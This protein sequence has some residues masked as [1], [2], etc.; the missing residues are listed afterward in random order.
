VS[1]EQALAAADAIAAALARPPTGPNR[2]GHP[3]SLSRGAAGV[4]LLH[5]ER[6]ASGLDGWDTAH[7][8][9]TAATHGT[10]SGNS[11]AALFFGT[12]ALAFSV[13][14]A[15][16]RPGKYQ[17]ALAAL[18]ANVAA[19]TRHRLDQA[20]ARI[21]RAAR[22]ALAEF[23]LING[24][25]GLGACLLRRDPD[26]DLVRQVLAY[27]VRLTEPLPGDDLPGWWTSQPPT[28]RRPAGPGGGHGNF[29]I[30]HGIAG[31][32]ALLALA[33]RSG[34][35]TDGQIQAIATICTWFDTWQ[36]EQQGAPW[37]PETITLAETRTGHTAQTRPLRPSWC[38]G[39]PGLARAQQLAALATGDTKRLTM[40]EA[41][42]NACLTDPA[43]LARITDHSLCHG[44]AG[45]F[46]TTVRAAA[47]TPS[48]ARHLPGLSR[49]LLTPG[50][51]AAPQTGVLEGDA[52]LAL[53]LSSAGTRQLPAVGWD[54]FLLLT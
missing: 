16:D 35:R 18:D 51:A 53:A 23:D 47:D 9:L 34:I 31:P 4:A 44:W 37:W 12:P 7:D 43:Q 41:A 36:Q 6:A 54:A 52:G 46:Q 33:A 42:L 28:G 15:A 21:D 1:A 20:H 38:Y 29:G 27:L 48:L 45:L 8:W 11:N 26:G 19:I 14:A 39:T 32:L 10:L 5:I 50:T 49:Q 3:Q 13:H 30:A 2:G 22:P 17:R 24:L 25:T 40:A